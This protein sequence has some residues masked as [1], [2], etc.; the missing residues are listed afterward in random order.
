MGVTR[1]GNVISSRI[2]TW[3]KS[4]LRPRNIK[5]IQYNGGNLR[6]LRGATGISERACPDRRL[7]MSTE[8]VDIPGLVRTD[9]P[10]GCA[11]RDLAEIPG[12]AAAG[13]AWRMYRWLVVQ[14][15]VVQDDP[16]SA[17]KAARM[18]LARPCPGGAQRGTRG[19]ESGRLSV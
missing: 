14:Q 6:S 11:H 12:G 19:L 10:F 3:I 7:G 9:C 4:V 15:V 18:I 13:R 8:S 5:R 17:D 1:V 2:W 16:G